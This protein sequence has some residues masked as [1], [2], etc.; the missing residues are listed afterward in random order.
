MLTA[1][2]KLPLFLIEILQV[3][4]L[5]YGL[6]SIASGAIW[7]ILLLCQDNIKVS[8]QKSVDTNIEVIA[9]IALDESS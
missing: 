4:Q 3:P 7:F 8:R 6:Y 2:I 5:F 1:Q 9:D